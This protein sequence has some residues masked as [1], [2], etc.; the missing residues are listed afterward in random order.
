[1]LCVWRSRFTAGEA[2]AADELPTLVRRSNA[3]LDRRVGR[4]GQG[5]IMRSLVFAKF[6]GAAADAGASGSR[7]TIAWVRVCLSQ[8]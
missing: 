5:R 2:L 8:L 1:V 4:T 6:A 3:P 7:R